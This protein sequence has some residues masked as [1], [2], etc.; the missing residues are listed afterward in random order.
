[1]RYP[2]SHKRRTGKSPA[3]HARGAGSPW[4]ETRYQGGTPPT[5]YG[6]TGQ[7][8]EAGIGLYYYNARWYDAK[9]GRFAQAD[10]I[11]TRDAKGFDRYAYVNNSSINYT[12]PTGHNS[13][14][15]EGSDCRLGICPQKIF[16]ERYW[17]WS[18]LILTNITLES[19]TGGLMPEEWTTERMGWVWEAVQTIGYKLKSVY[20]ELANF[21]NGQ[22]F[23]I[24]FSYVTFYWGHGGNENSI[25]KSNTWGG[26]VNSS[27]H[28]VNIYGNGANSRVF[29]RFIIH[30]LGHIYWNILGSP[31]VPYGFDRSLF[32][33]SWT[34]WQMHSCSVPDFAN[35]CNYDTE[36]FADMF[37]AWTNNAWSES[38][39][40][41]PIIASDWMDSLWQPPVNNNDN[42]RYNNKRKS[43]F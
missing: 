7:R 43:R 17:L 4:G 1:M 40:E 21:T 33:P 38:P 23:Q 13:S 41:T 39:G 22:A 35:D 11:R 14:S 18:Q 29:V 3:Q 30:E 2:R 16:H 42:I 32:R 31:T 37:L 20:K 10:T 28:Q 6:Y 15:I 27:M 24:I 8:E 34:G 12:D 5:D 26:C 9:L 36:L 25:C 19:S